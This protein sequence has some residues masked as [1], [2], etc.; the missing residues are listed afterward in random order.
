[1]L[2]KLLIYH[3]P[4][5]REM[6]AAIEFE[7]WQ[8]ANGYR[9]V[10]AESGRPQR[11]VRRGGKLL[12]RRPLDKTRALFLTFARSATSPEGVLEFIKQYGPLTDLGLDEHF[13]EPVPDAMREARMMAELLRH[14]NSGKRSLGPWSG[15]I[16]LP[17]IVIGKIDAFLVRD[18]KT[19]A[20]R[21][22]LSPS[23]LLHGLWLQL[24][25]DLSPG[26]PIRPCKH[27]GAWFEAGPGT[28]RRGD[29]E[30]CTRQHQILFNSLK[31]TKE[32]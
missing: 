7:W 17:W 1:M 12:M 18:A 16:A 19:K 13:G 14:H 23:N 24:A 27:C 21:L 20:L 26:T 10:D 4:T 9:L 32:K 22:Q 5:R 15:P 6:A 2:G 31:R 28:G 25:E 3:K 30:F 8:D 11:V 29:A